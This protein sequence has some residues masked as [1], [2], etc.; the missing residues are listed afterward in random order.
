[1][2]FASR[3]GEITEEIIF[4]AQREGVEP[5][6]FRSEISR[7][8]AIICSKKH[9]LELEPHIIGRMF[10]IGNSGITSSIEEEVEKLQWSML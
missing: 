5:E 6:F 2:Y 10:N 4:V 1:M 8:Q 7:G 9:H 3:R